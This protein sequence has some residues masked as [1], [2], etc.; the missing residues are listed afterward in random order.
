MAKYKVQ[1]SKTYYA[2]GDVEVEA[3]SVAE[4]GKMVHENMGN[5]TGSMQY[6]PDRDQV[7]VMVEE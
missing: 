5:Y 1:W 4:A 7:E 2:F 3:N 6:D